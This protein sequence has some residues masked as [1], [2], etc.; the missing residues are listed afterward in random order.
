LSN[1]SDIKSIIL[2]FLTL[3]ATSTALN[4][5]TA[6]GEAQGQSPGEQRFGCD[7]A[8][9]PSMID[10][11]MT[12]RLIEAHGEAVIQQTALK[13]H[14]KPSD[15]A[16]II[17]LLCSDAA[18]VITGEAILVNGGQDM[19]GQRRSVRPRSTR[20]QPLSIRVENQQRFDRKVQPE[21][22]PE[23]GAPNA[24]K[25][26]PGAGIEA[27]KGEQTHGGACTQCAISF[28]IG[29]AQCIGRGPGLGGQILF[30]HLDAFGP[31]SRCQLRWTLAG[32]HV[33]E[34]GAPDDGCLFGQ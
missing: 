11:P 26:S 29:L 33:A 1:I 7:E 14:G 12:A 27:A 3:R 16:S 6:S 10:A 22:L 20:T 18:S 31:S 28:G 5:P 30:G 21:R 15:I 8:V 19:G 34:R 17:A 32:R 2:F 4:K 25:N 23:L 9:S 13:R 24:V